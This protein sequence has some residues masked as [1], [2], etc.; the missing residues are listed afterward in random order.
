M[1]DP[2]PP[3]RAARSVAA[4][5][6][7]EAAMF[8]C[9]SAASIA[10]AVAA[11]LTGTDRAAIAA[12]PDGLLPSGPDPDAARGFG[13]GCGSILFCAAHDRDLGAP[14]RQMVR[15]GGG[16]PMPVG[17]ADGCASALVEAAAARPEVAAGLFLVE[18]GPEPHPASARAMLPHFL[19]ALHTRG[20][21]V[22]VHTIDAVE[23]AGLLDAGAD[24]L[25]LEASMLPGS[26]MDAPVP[27][28][29]VPECHGL[30]IVAGR[31]DLVD[32]CRAQRHGIGAAMQPCSAAITAL[33]TRIGTDHP[34][35]PTGRFALHSGP[36]GT[37]L[38]DEDEAYL[39]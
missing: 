12:L 17:D 14:V 16:R 33:L 36:D 28:G 18:D 8:T 25:L 1:T 31:A 37:L 39:R 3:D 6:E 30:G 19:F 2:A 21:P 22:I 26:M 20:L 38:S 9:G 24:L 13:A 34:P 23:P 10:I 11:C 32:A 7:A 29:S 15:L 5:L 35:I 4:L 27:D